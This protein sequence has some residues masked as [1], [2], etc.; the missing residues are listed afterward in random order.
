MTVASPYIQFLKRV[1]AASTVIVSA[2]LGGTAIFAAAETNADAVSYVIRSWRTIDGLP[3]NSV[4]A[5]A[6]TPDGYLWVGTKGG[7]ARFDGVRF[8]NYGLAEGLKG[9]N[10]ARLLEDGK[11]GLWIA[12][13]GG[14]LSHWQNGVISTLT[15][16]DGL[17]H[18]DVTALAPAEAG[19]VWVG[20]KGG[21]Q[22]HGPGGFSR[23]F[24]AEGLR[25]E[26][27]ALAADRDGGLW[28]TVA[29][30]GVFYC[31]GGRCEPVEG[32]PGK[33]L[34][35]GY[36]LL[37][38]RQGDLWMG[39]GNGVV[40]RR[41]A[42]EWKQL[43]RTNGVP[44]SAIFCLAQGPAGEIWAGSQAA[45]L[46][47]FRAGRFHAA[48]GTDV[49][50]RAAQAG[51][52]GVIWVGTVTSGLS[53][54]THRKLMEYAVGQ[55]KRSWDV[56]GLV[57]EPPGRFWVTTFGGGLFRGALDRL[58]PVSDIP[59]LIGYPHLTTGFKLSNGALCFAGNK[60]LLQREAGAG[61][62]HAVTF[63]GSVKALCE[64]LDGSLWLGTREGEL[65]RVLEGTLQPVTNGTFPAAINGLVRGPGESLW[66]A[67]QEP[68]SSAGK[69]AESAIGAWP[70]DCPPANCE[71][72][73]GTARKPCGLARRAAAWPGW[74]KGMCIQWTPGRASA[75]TSSRKI[76][77]DKGNL[78][79][80]A[81]AASPACPSA[82]SGTCPRA[83]PPP[84][85]R[86]CWTK[87]MAC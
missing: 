73:T 59:A 20:S 5:L 47:V 15:T 21:L 50:V 65:K 49:T 72:S 67:T 56:G 23:I 24:E 32:P 35:H 61:E 74:R 17:A 37:V 71:R 16:A 63:Q 8:V 58:E 28:M 29:A 10:I 27:V 3:Q 62:F 11:G 68:G 41:H 53:R 79:S 55:D 9:L 66:V 34:P 83:G 14:G 25:G 80:V 26:V 13:L 64:S 81:T 42:G 87:R 51:S 33:R 48:P 38:D 46:Y 45:G 70:K 7:L 12:T 60:L 4:T 82:N 31:K 57:E 1:M 18:N 2:N 77:E 84:C 39:I 36:C 86:W 22:H 44:F 30:D 52:D 69:R 40:L 43:N 6:Q 76:L 78:G 54:L 75:T 85:I 19:G